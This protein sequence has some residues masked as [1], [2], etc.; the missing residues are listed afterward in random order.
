MRDSVINAF[1]SGS[2]PSAL[3][4]DAEGMVSQVFLGLS[5]P[6]AVVAT[7][8]SAGTSSV[9]FTADLLAMHIAVATI[10]KLTT[11]AVSAWSLGSGGHMLKILREEQRKRLSAT[12]GFVASRRRP[13]LQSCLN[14]MIQHRLASR[15]A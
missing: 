2:T 7:L 5:L 13:Q 10:D 15:H 3:A 9:G 1:C 14:C 4:V 12:G 6:S 11:V 8:S